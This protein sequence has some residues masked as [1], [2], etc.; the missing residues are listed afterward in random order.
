MVRDITL[1]Y[2]SLDLW[3]PRQFNGTCLPLFQDIHKFFQSNNTRHTHPSCLCGVN[4][5]FLSLHSTV[6]QGCPA[7]NMS[8]L[9]VAKILPLW[10]THPLRY[11]SWG[12]VWQQL[13]ASNLGP[14]PE[15]SLTEASLVLKRRSEFYI[16]FMNPDTDI[17]QRKYSMHDPRRE[18]AI[19]S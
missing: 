7:K 18:V 14:L 12:A 8:S 3:K 16:F 11:G 5:W 17:L 2:N 13:V 15:S 1:R 19:G 10:P 6:D 9:L 4:C